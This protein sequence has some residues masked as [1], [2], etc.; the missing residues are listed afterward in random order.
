MP[1]KLLS[2]PVRDATGGLLQ[3]ILVVGASHGFVYA[4]TFLRSFFL[5]R[6]LGPDAYG[7]AVILI[8]ITAALDV[9]ADAGIDRFVVQNRFGYRQ[10]VMKTAHAFRVFGS[11]VV[12]LGIAVL[13]FPVSKAVHAPNL[14]LPIASTGGIVAIRG[15]VNLSY[16][17]QQRHHRFGREAWISAIV[18]S[19]E[20]IVTTSVAIFTKSYLA[21]LAG[22]YVNA[23]AHVILSHVVAKGP[24]SFLPRGRLIGLVT[25]FS[26]PIYINAALLVSAQSDRLVIATSYSKRDVAYYAT[27]SAI[28]AGITSL[29]RSMIMQIMLPRLAQH[30]GVSGMTSPPVN[31]LTAG[32]IAFSVFYLIGISLVGP[33]L[34][35]VL[36]GPAFRG[37]G[38]LV[39]ASAITQMIQLEQA[40]L[41]TLLI[42][43]GLTRS[44]P[45]ITFVRATAFPAALLMA[46]L[47]FS[48]VAVPLAF[49]F[50]EMLSL[51]VSYFAARELRAIDGRLIVASFARVILVVGVVIY[52][53]RT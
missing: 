43:N 23:I 35:G 30:R 1:L 34:V 7:F 48:I 14:L 29:A 20:I 5:A 38:T 39:Y 32:V 31:Q 53:V 11:A 16:K 18:C 46:K 25:R 24:Y 10:D 8:T 27:A 36:Y 3:N 21:V 17:L 49:A 22:A 19:L 37:L 4:S 12:G 6:I 51:A 47:G 9:F 52:L 45:V 26:A 40:W 13:S 33:T 42:A 41:V 50:G 44:I 28:G 2:K 15:F